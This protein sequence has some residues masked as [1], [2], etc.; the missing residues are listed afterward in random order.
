MRHM[1]AAALLVLAATASAATNDAPAVY[2]LKCTEAESISTIRLD[3]GV[4]LGKVI[5]S[6]YRLAL[7]LN[8]G[9]QTATIIEGEAAQAPIVNKAG[10]PIF[11][12]YRRADGQMFSFAY[13]PESATLLRASFSDDTPWGALAVFKCIPAQ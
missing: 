6:T 5:P 11:F 12:M 1:I 10:T 2:A 9:T 13:H 8:Q 7:I 3:S 4:Q